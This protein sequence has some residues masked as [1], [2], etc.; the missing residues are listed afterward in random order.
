MKERIAATKVE[1]ARTGAGKPKPGA[2]APAPPPSGVNADL[3]VDVPPPPPA[4]A[5]TAKASSPEAERANRRL[6][7]MQARLAE[8][9]ARGALEKG[10]QARATF[11]AAKTD[12]LMAQ[13]HEA[14]VE[15]DDAG[16][17][18]LLAKAEALDPGDPRVALARADLA[19]ERGD[20]PLAQAE[21]ER[22]LAHD[23]NVTLVQY[24]LGSLYARLGDRSRAAYFLEQAVVNFKPNTGARR[25]AEFE[26]ARLEFK[27]LEHSG[28][29]TDAGETARREF[30]RGQPVIW[31]GKV[32]Q[33]FYP[34]N[35][36]FRVRWRSPAGESVFQESLRM[37]PG[38]NVASK[39]RTGSLAPGA[40]RVEVS[41]EDTLIETIDFELA[42][43]S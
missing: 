11:D 40:W 8:L 17:D 15:G 38:G 28:L 31:W 32:S 27:I 33:R 42:S 10:L 16:A 43:G 3:G 22:A 30:R 13:A 2:P 34:L 24:Q 12:P 36:E 20:L 18:A 35:P 4:G 25:R 39:L 41:V 19:T 29:A 21:L 23:P 6:A 5:A 37:S 7:E 9:S 14:R 26:L 1:I